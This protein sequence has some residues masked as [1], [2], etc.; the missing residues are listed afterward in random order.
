[1]SI[2]TLTLPTKTFNSEGVYYLSKGRTRMKFAYR[3]SCL[4]LLV[5]LCLAGCGSGNDVPPP[6]TSD[7]T[8]AEGFWQGLTSNNRVIGGVVLDDGTYW[9]LYAVSGNPNL[10]AG[11]VQGTGS[12]FNGVFSSADGKDFNLEG[13]GTRTFTSSGN[14]VQKSTLNGTLSESD[15]S[16]GSFTSTYDTNY[17]LAP[18]LAT[19]AGTY[20]NSNSTE[21][22]TVNGAGSIT[23][24]N[25]SG[26]NATGSATPRSKGN[27]YNVIVNIGPAPCSLPNQAVSGVAALTSS[28]K[29][30]LSAGLNPAR[31]GGFIFI[32][33]K[34]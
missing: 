7:G 5:M 8:S 10:V 2:I 15:G 28:N 6:V 14:Y 26:C 32:G 20:T 22:V 29:K 11:L 21:T 18:S 13:A 34:P 9:F 23:Y 17:D 12:S 19:L 27:V 33:T 25:T 1:M 4:I 16:T 24:S 31:T 3:A 30:L